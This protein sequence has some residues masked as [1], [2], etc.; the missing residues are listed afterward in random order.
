M[1]TILT[2][3]AFCV[4]IN[5]F[6]RSY[7]INRHWPMYGGYIADKSLRKRRCCSLLIFL[8]V[9]VH[10]SVVMF[11][12]TLKNV[13]E[14]LIHAGL[15]G[16]DIIY[17]MVFCNGVARAFYGPAAFTVLWRIAYQKNFTQTQ[18]PGIAR[19]GK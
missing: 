19:A 2:K 3:S 9:I 6:K 5:R 4:G 11:T 16:A 10:Q 1:Y 15:D 17:A 14:S 7:P 12:V 18:A 8:L 13:T